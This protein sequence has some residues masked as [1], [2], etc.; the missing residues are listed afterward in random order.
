MVLI[1]A[2]PNGTLIYTRSECLFKDIEDYLLGE[3]QLVS[4]L[5]GNGLPT[6]DA[7]SKA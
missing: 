7:F 6:G 5:E 4:T 1:T 2:S 3:R